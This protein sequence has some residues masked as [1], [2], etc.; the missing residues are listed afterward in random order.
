VEEFKTKGPLALQRALA[1]DKLMLFEEFGATG[2]NK[3]QV[4]RD[5]IA[6]FNGL[7]VPWMPW[8][9]SKP[10]NGAKD[11][12]FWTDEPAYGAVKQGALQAG[13]AK[14]AQKWSVS[15]SEKRQI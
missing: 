7:G 14:S 4:L 2:E 5:H 8:Q 12:E 13:K 6:V 9:I 10:G 1:A 3:A 15:A 11:F